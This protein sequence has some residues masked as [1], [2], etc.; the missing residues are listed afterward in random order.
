[1]MA[2]FQCRLTNTMNTEDHFLEVDQRCRMQ[3]LDTTEFNNL[4][5]CSAPNDK[6]FTLPTG[7]EKY[8]KKHG[9]VNLPIDIRRENLPWILGKYSDTLS[10]PPNSLV[11]LMKFQLLMMFYPKMRR[12]TLFFTIVTVMMIKTL[13]IQNISQNV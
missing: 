10:L 7:C 11:L 6:N 3:T 4:E 9:N 1:M 8:E 5:Y 2:G 12:R 13:Y